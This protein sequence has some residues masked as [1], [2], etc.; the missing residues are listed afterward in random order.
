[1]EIGYPYRCGE[2]GFVIQRE[3]VEEMTQLFTEW[4][5]DNAVPTGPEHSEEAV[6][7]SDMEEMLTRMFQHARRPGRAPQNP[8]FQVADL[9]SFSQLLFGGKSAAEP[10]TPMTAREL[11]TVTEPTR[12]RLTELAGVPAAELVKAPIPVPPVLSQYLSESGGV[13]N[14]RDLIQVGTLSLMGALGAKFERV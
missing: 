12:V 7:S 6:S 8:P 9:K 5:Q 4:S 11:L 2:H 10:K 1:V 3:H 13:F 14:P